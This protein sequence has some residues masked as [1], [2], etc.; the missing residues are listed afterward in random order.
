[1]SQQIRFCTSAE[2]V[3]LA[4]SISGNGPPLAGLR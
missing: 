2:G 1:M 4:Y 3:R